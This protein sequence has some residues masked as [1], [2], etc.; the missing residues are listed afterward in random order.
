MTLDQYLK[1]NGLTQSAFAALIG[2]DQTTIHR[3]LASGQ[4]PSKPT[5][6]KI[7]E[8]TNGA[9]TPNDFFEVAA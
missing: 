6:I 4:I 5:M 2:V 8:K 1:S 9:V 7:V 3:M